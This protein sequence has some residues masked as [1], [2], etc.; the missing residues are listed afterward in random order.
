MV[1]NVPGLEGWDQHP[2]RES[3]ALAVQ[4]ECLA[5]CELRPIP[6]LSIH[7]VKVSTI[8]MRRK[9]GGISPLLSIHSMPFPS[10]TSHVNLT[11][12]T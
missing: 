4:E 10:P 6:I 9:V 3:P 2:A 8:G 5:D 7:F 11:V 1:Q 12:G